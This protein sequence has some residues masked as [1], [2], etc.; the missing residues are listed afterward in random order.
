VYGDN[1]ATLTITPNDGTADGESTVV[2]ID[3]T[4]VNDQPE[5]SDLT[6]VTFAENTVNSTPQQIDANITLTDID[7]GDGDLE[8]GYLLITGLESEDTISLPTDAAGIW[9][10][11]R[12][13]DKVHYSNTTS[14]IGVIDSTQDGV[15]G[16]DFRIDFNTS[17]MTPL[18][19]RIA[20][21]LEQL[22]Y[23]NNSDTPISTR[24]LSWSVYDG[25]GNE[26]A[27]NTSDIEITI[28]EE[29]DAPTSEDNTAMATEDTAYIFSIDDFNFADVD[30][31][32]S[33]SSVK[34]TSL[35]AV[36]ALT[37]N[38][39][40]VT[41]DQVI[42]A[43]SIA[44]GS[45]VFT[46]EADANGGAYDAFEYSVNDGTV[47]S[48]ASYTMTID[49]AVVND[50]PLITSIDDQTI[51][52]DAG[53]FIVEVS[54]SDVEGDDI[55][56]T[57]SISDESLATVEVT[58]TWDQIGAD[59]SGEAAGDSSG[60]SVSLSADGQTIVIG[61]EYN[62][63]NGTNSGHVRVYTLSDGGWSQ[64]GED[65]DG[66]AGDRS[67][68]VVSISGDGLT[69]A[70]SARQDDTNGNNSGVVR[71]YRHGEDSWSQV[72][73]IYGEAA[74]DQL[75]DSI[76]LSYD[77][78]IISVGTQYNDG[79][80]GRNSGHVR[81][82]EDNGEG[83]WSQLGLDI[84]GESAD[85]WSG[86]SSALSSDGQTIAIGS[87]G[88]DGGGYNSGQVQVFEY[89]SGSDTWNQ[90]GTDIDGESSGDGSG[91]S[92][93]ISADG[94]TVAIAAPYS[95]SGT[96]EVNIYQ[97][98][99]ASWTKAG[100]SIISEA[101]LNEV[102]PFDG[103]TSTELAVSLSA[104]G[105]TV[106][107]G[108]NN[109]DGNGSDSGH[110]RIF[111]LTDGAWE[112][113]STDIDG[114]SSGDYSGG[115]VS[116]S[117]DGQSIAIGSRGAD[118]YAGQV[119][120]YNL[121]EGVLVTPTANANGNA[122]VTITATDSNGASSDSSFNLTTDAVND[123]PISSDNTVTTD[124]DVAYTFGVDDFNFVDVDGGDSLSSVKITSLEAA[125]ALILNGEA[126]AQD[127]VITAA[128]IA[129]GSL[130]FTPAADANGSAYD[131]FEYS[132][133]DGTVDS[134]SYTMI[135]DVAAVNDAPTTSDSSV[136][137][138][139]DSVYT[140]TADDFEYADAE[141]DPIVGVRIY[142]DTISGNG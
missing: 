130:V 79:I 57:A 48:D 96:G 47:D 112:Q 93:S 52:E 64:L 31:G 114:E 20:R 12:I 16:N 81:I 32:N 5:I 139:E 69:I 56:Y 101:L 78:Q 37:L 117:A 141:G 73:E 102:D 75:A 13:G 43:A 140:F 23:S 36:G 30:S 88:A 18:P 106:A 108:T 70:V 28:T 90:L 21:V 38:D 85:D 129:E 107:I 100:D 54:A 49:V 120:V 109:N 76:S 84:D 103:G 127:Q 142:A 74:N 26:V 51:Q 42:T 35:E 91:K 89:N 19:A 66:Q 113:V 138:S 105:L 80:A 121:K 68:R 118:G 27:T 137:T 3:I 67:G 4:A 126:V 24:T 92:I 125:G 98:D 17:N 44:A 15:N 22:T 119:K 65:I 11:Q 94:R 10:V 87:T 99:G 14:H 116:L 104:D 1:A 115:S 7:I 41:Q 135:V 71:V 8:G 134:G 53:S 39:E 123:A 110:V 128:S 97:Y 133:N 83:G 77:G 25:D 6:D 45:L 122:T 60:G 132:V 86:I 111:Q 131:A 2:N 59:I 62:D 95:D 29:N 58:S 72:G 46:P 34:I 124:E 33:L 136:S 61:A 50:A 9:N 63:D 40:A 82:Y 55:T